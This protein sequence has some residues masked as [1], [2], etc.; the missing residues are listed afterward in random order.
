[1][2]KK[3][4]KLTEYS[5][6][7][8]KAIIANYSQYGKNCADLLKENFG[9][10]TKEFDKAFCGRSYHSV[11]TITSN[12]KNSVQKL[13]ASV[14]VD[15]ASMPECRSILHLETYCKLTEQTP[16][17]VLCVEDTHPL[18]NDVEFFDREQTVA[19][20]RV[21]AQA[22]LSEATRNEMIETFRTD[23]CFAFG[24]FGYMFNVKLK[25][26][27]YHSISLVLVVYKDSTKYE[28]SLDN[29]VK[30]AF[31]VFNTS[32]AFPTTDMPVIPSRTP[33]SNYISLML[34]DELKKMYNGRTTSEHKDKLK[35][36]LNKRWQTFEAHI[37]S[38]YKYALDEYKKQTDNLSAPSLSAKF[39][40]VFESV[41]NKGLK[42]EISLVMNSDF[43]KLYPPI[44]EGV[45]EESAV[46]NALY[47]ATQRSSN[48]N[49]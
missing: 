48:T 29:Q 42:K 49:E 34:S 40:K 16:N 28:H 41:N 5:L 39:M 13:S 45:A 26:S 4:R 43:F 25:S 20:C 32:H 33:T 15:A 8:G 14:D 12:W 6:A 2:S 30:F 19:L 17:Q 1:M 7:L 36:E 44:E 37:R 47:D 23:Q 21:L 9:E 22:D 18:P 3:P 46:D 35:Q 24:K 11:E 10:G 31:H 38:A 27:P